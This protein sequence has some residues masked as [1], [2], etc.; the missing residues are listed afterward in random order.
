MRKNRHENIVYIFFLIFKYFYRI[1]F[2]VARRL[3]QEGAKVIISSRR[4]V[5]VKSA[6]EELKNEG[7][8]VTG[9][10]CHVAKAEDREKLLNEVIHFENI[11]M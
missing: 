2:S 8:E 3:A 11:F 7:L 4:N 5:N 9:I 10:T 1:G 6:V